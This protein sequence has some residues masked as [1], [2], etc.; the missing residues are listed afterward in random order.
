MHI[1]FGHL[2]KSESVGPGIGG[3]EVGEARGEEQGRGEEE[4]E[5]EG[6]LK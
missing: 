4:D 3:G 5:G 2:G 1:I 6:N